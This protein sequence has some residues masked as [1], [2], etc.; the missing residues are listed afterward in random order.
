VTTISADISQ[1]QKTSALFYLVRIATS[2]D[3]I[4]R[5]GKVRLV[6]GMPVEVYVRSDDRTVMSFFVKPL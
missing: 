4:A 3:E 5:L 6:P 1:D 2:A